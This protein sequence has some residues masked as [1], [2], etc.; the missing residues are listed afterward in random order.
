MLA[1]RDLVAH[2]WDDYA[3]LALVLVDNL[4]GLYL[5]VGLLVGE[6]NLESLGVEELVAVEHYL[7]SPPSGYSLGFLSFLF[8]LLPLLLLLLGPFLWRH[9]RRKAFQIFYAKPGFASFFEICNIFSVVVA[10]L[11]ALQLGV[12]ELEGV[13]YDPLL[14]VERQVHLHLLCF[15]CLKFAFRDVLST[16]K[17]EE[18]WDYAVETLFFSVPGGGHHSLAA[19]HQELD[20][21][22]G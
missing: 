1:E 4:C 12:V 13:G 11:K 18:G 6:A 9:L 7:G 2:V 20:L 15:D 14:K 3:N 10:V 16:E 19:L 17:P 22:V 8:G 5:V 21:L